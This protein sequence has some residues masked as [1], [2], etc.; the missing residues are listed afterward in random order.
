MKPPVDEL[1]G[2]AP[3]STCRKRNTVSRV[4]A[5]AC[6]SFTKSSVTTVWFVTR[7]DSTSLTDSCADVECAGRQKRTVR[8]DAAEKRRLS[9]IREEQR[10]LIDRQGLAG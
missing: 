2:R 4:A 10:R 9:V 8:S 7:N 6:R 5:A 3:S 1:T